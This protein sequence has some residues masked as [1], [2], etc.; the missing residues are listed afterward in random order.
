MR[1][2]NAKLLA[3]A[4][5]LEAAFASVAAKAPGEAA[6]GENSKRRYIFKN[7]Q[8]DSMHRLDLFTLPCAPAKLD[9]YLAKLKADGVPVEYIDYPGMI[10]GY[11]RAFA[12]VDVARQT[13]VESARSIR[14]A[15]GMP[16]A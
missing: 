3:G 13:I 14:A 16:A 9:A 6:P 2:F 7:L 5:A 10:H 4:A 8:Y 11:L 15:F 1:A 12:I